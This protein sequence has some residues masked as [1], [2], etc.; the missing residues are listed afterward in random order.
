MRDKKTV[1]QELGGFHEYVQSV[2][3]HSC[4]VVAVGQ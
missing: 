1:V 2:I 4:C 3:Q